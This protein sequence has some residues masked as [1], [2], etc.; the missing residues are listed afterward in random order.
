MKVLKPGSVLVLILGL[1]LPLA[2]CDI[3]GGI[4][5]SVQV[6]LLNR[7]NSEYINMVYSRNLFHAREDLG[8]DHDVFETVQLSWQKYLD[9]RWSILAQQGYRWNI[10][11]SDEGEYGLNGL[12]NTNIAVNYR[13]LNRSSETL[14]FIWR[15][16][17]SCKLPTGRFEENLYDKNLPDNFNPSDGSWGVGLS[18]DLILSASNHGFI[19]N[20]DYRLSFKD[21]RNYRRGA[22]ATAQTTYYMNKET[23]ELTVMPYGSIFYEWIDEYRYP[24]ER[25]ID[26]TGGHGLFVMAGLNV[27]MKNFNFG[28][29]YSHPIVSDYGEGR[30]SAGGRL[31]FQTT[32]LF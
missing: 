29:N 19:L 3:C 2:A 16:G 12:T 27:D 6:G 5:S 11:Y 9:D 28:L 10:R 25:V 14:N 30:I 17:L 20:T 21:P 23:G 1:G 4:T 7:V 13:I 26:G 18:N 32:Y 8:Y 24:S 31:Q 15:S 22:T